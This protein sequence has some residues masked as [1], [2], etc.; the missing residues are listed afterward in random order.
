[1]GLETNQ[2]TRGLPIFIARL[3]RCKKL[4][5]NGKIASGGNYSAQKHNQFN[6]AIEDWID[7]FTFTAFVDRDGMYQQVASFEL[8]IKTSRAICDACT[9]LAQ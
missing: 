8:P 7:F 9:D 1:L 3:G 5:K 2:T 6:Q 4:V